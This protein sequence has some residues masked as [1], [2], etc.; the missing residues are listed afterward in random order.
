MRRPPRPA[1]AHRLP[2]RNTPARPTA[3]ARE[4]R[5]RARGPT[6]CTG[7]RVDI[8][9]N[10]A[11]LAGRY[12]AA[13][14]GLARDQRSLDAVGVSLATVER[15]LAESADF[16]T[17]TRSPL[18]ARADAERGVGVAADGLGVDPLTRNFLL[19]L[20]R[21][22]R[23]AALPAIIREYRAMAAD[24]RGEATAQVTAARALSEAQQEQLRDLLRAKLRRAVA[25][26]VRV[27]PAIL[28]GLVVKVG[29]RLID[30]SIRTKLAAVGAAMM[31]G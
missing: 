29:S 9:G 12:A 14:F 19:V 30:S 6:I 11:G 25:L 21:G 15:A 8:G 13:L 16:A 1:L 4:P 2:R 10:T 31:K 26:D 22:R 3:S 28:G 27:D 5:F 23:L 7:F 17:L 24:A 18:I 20:A